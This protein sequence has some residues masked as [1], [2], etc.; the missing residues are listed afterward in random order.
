ML[1]IL[2]QSV[3]VFVQL[4]YL[5]SLLL[6]SCLHF[7]APEEELVFMGMVFWVAGHDSE[8][9][10]SGGMFENGQGFGDREIPWERVYPSSRVSPLRF[11][12]Q[13]FPQTTPIVVFRILRVSGSSEHSPVTSRLQ[14][15]K[16][17]RRRQWCSIVPPMAKLDFFG[18]LSVR[19]VVILIENV[20]PHLV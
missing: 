5:P 11:L 12:A 6:L 10:R 19:T 8:F 1:I 20:V 4:G 15:I 13:R 3:C 17:T 16:Q 9:R 14:P 2:T 7:L 18:R